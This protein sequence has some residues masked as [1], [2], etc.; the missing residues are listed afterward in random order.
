MRKTLEVSS[1]RKV[2]ERKMKVFAGKQQTMEDRENKND[3][4]TT[5]TKDTCSLKTC[6]G[7]KTNRE[8]YMEILNGK[9]NPLGE[10]IDSTELSEMINNSIRKAVRTIVKQCSMV[11]RMQVSPMIHLNN[12]LLF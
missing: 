6:G 2:E 10:K 3:Q 8:N 11:S 12:L 4:R 7:E 5:E 1:P 9:E